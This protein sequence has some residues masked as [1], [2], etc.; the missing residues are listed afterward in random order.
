M[1]LTVFPLISARKRGEFDV[2]EAL[3]ET[4]KDNH[5]KIQDG[6][7][8]VISTKYISNSQG[9]IV[10]TSNIKPSKKGREISKKFQMKPQI[11]EIVLRESDKIFGGITGFVI[12]SSDNIMAPNAGIDKSNAKKDHVILYPNNPFL[13]AEQ[14]RRK[15]F[16]KFSVHI[17]VILVDSRLMPA[18]IGTS[19]IAIAC[20]GIEPVLDMRAQKDLDG[21]PL[22]VTFQAVIDNIATIANHKMGEGSESKPFAIVRDSDAKLTDRKINPSEMAISPDQCVYVRGLANA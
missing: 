21:N 18:R 6:D 11:A 13:I 20:A 17:G 7:V 14:L 12:T 19:G 9:R 3:L 10:N 4:L 16:L 1:S 15:I 8:L 2:F 22:K 5:E